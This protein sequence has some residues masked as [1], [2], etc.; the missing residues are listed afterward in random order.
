MSQ[1]ER[2]VLSNFHYD[3]YREFDNFYRIYPTNS[4]EVCYMVGFERAITLIDQYFRSSEGEMVI[5][6]EYNEGYDDGYQEGFDD[7]VTEGLMQGR[8]EGY[9]DGY[10]QGSEDAHQNAS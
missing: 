7:G 2:N 10:A 4:P 1:P 9:E 6:E 8:S 5:A 3:R